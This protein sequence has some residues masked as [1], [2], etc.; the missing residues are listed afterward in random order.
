[1][2]YKFISLNIEGDKHVERQ[3]SFF[4]EE[5]PDILCLQEITQARFEVLRKNFNFDGVFAHQL[6]G[7]GV[8]VL[9]KLPILSRSVIT[10]FPGDKE[11]I[12]QSGNSQE[13]HDRVLAVAVLDLFGVKVRIITTHLPKNSIGSITSDF[14]H[15]V[16]TACLQSLQQFDSF[17]LCGDI[18][19]PRGLQIFEK[20]STCYQDCVPSTYTTSIDGALHRAG[21]LPYMVDGLF[22]HNAPVKIHSVRLQSGVSDHMAVCSILE[23]K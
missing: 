4:K 2:Q 9:T 16:L 17:V 19:A 10:F 1:M 12:D 11:C 5:N 6:N 18:N 15:T 8:A 13:A 14:Q 21:S 23:T 20:L 3:L 7:D 22:T